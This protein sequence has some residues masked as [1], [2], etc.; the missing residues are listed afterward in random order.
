MRYIEDLM[1]NVRTRA[2]IDCLD[3]LALLEHLVLRSAEEPATSAIDIPRASA[4]TV[5]PDFVN[6]VGAGR[7]TIGGRRQAGLDEI[8]TGIARANGSELLRHLFKP[9]PARSPP[10]GP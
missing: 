10:T 8:Q 3:C 6:P 1:L 9:V 5:V 4:S 7:Q 2:I